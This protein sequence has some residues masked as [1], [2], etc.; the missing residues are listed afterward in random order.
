[1]KA[2]ALTILGFA[3]LAIFASNHHRLPTTLLAA[4]SDKARASSPFR[5]KLTLLCSGRFVDCDGFAMRTRFCSSWTS[6]VGPE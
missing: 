4:G 1:M 3:A 5:V 6:P 2:I